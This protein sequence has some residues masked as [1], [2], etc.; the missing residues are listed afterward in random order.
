MSEQLNLT[1]QEVAGLLRIAKNTVYELVKRGELNY[2]KV[3][4][5]MRFTRSDVD[6]YIADSRRGRVHEARIEAAP[7]HGV[8]TD[9]GFII[10]GQDPMLD[11]L[12]GHLA[13]RANVDRQALRSYTGSYE[14]LI[15]LYRSDVHAA[16]A[17][18]WDGDSGQYNVPYVR[19]LLPGVPCL[20]I[21]LTGRIQGLFVA[22]GNPKGVK[23]WEDFRRDDLRM[24]NREKGAG[25]RV[26]LDEH[27]RLMKVRGRDIEGYG[28]EEPSHL[29]VAGVV[30]RG[31]ADLGVGDFKAAGQ[32]AGVD[33]LPLQNEQYDLIIKKDDFGLSIVK[34]ILEI[35]RSKEFISQ[36]QNMPGYDVKGIGEIVAEI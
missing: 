16:T 27:L 9:S 30:G 36:F 4:R 19:R 6:E 5:K 2:Y 35:L 25:S 34:S 11:V 7:S 3:G 18:L 20:V 8:S 15:A 17:H 29:S 10:T 26:L 21:H 32:V 31:E 13:R 22:C 23:G 24:V 28:R 14:G 33:F 1:A 12:T